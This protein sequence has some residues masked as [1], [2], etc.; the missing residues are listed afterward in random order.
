MGTVGFEQAKTALVMKLFYACPQ[1]QFSG[2]S[3]EAA[4]ISRWLGIVV[5]KHQLSCCYPGN[6]PTVFQE[7]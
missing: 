5:Q 6:K 1:L 4:T 7:L 2:F 3:P